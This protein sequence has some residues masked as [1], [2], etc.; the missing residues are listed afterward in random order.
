MSSFESF[1]CSPVKS[2]DV[3]QTTEIC[4]FWCSLSLYRY[5]VSIFATIM[6]AQE[7]KQRRIEFCRN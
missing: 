7:R 5:F 4:Y 6:A 2:V 3:L 1:V